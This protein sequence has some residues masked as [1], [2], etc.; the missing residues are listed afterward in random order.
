MTARI[1]SYELS[2]YGPTS[3]PAGVYLCVVSL[4]GELAASLRVI[5]MLG[6]GDRLAPESVIDSTGIHG[7]APAP[8]TGGRLKSAG[9]PATWARR[10]APRLPK[11]RHSRAADRAIVLFWRISRFLLT[12]RDG[13]AI[14]T[15]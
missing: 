10:G 11:P 9:A 8:P 13:Y 4:T 7:R 1:S 5:A 2:R 12:I 14:E 3:F 6:T 15:A